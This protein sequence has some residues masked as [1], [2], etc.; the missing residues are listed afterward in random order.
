MSAPTSRDSKVELN[1]H[2]GATW[3][4]GYL[5]PLYGA[6]AML[7]ERGGLQFG[8]SFDILPRERWT[9]YLFSLGIERVFLRSR[10]VRPFLGL[11]VGG[12]A[13]NADSDPFSVD[14]SSPNLLLPMVAGIGWQTGGVDAAWLFRTE[15]R[16]DV[17]VR[18][19]D[20]C[21]GAVPVS[22]GSV[23]TTCEV[24]G[25]IDHNWGFSVGFSWFL[26]D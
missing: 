14:R 6:R 15:I 8:G 1:I 26:G 22:G 2:A 21:D 7:L 24:E 23:G 4:E 16:N 9:G 5:G 3:V 19:D 17:V 18:D 20:R 12:M 11:G 10:L 25:G 13:V